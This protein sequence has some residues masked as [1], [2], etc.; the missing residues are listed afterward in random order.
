MSSADYGACLCHD[1]PFGGLG[2]VMEFCHVHSEIPSNPLFLAYASC[3]PWESLT[4]PSVAGTSYLV[5]G[6][7]A[8]VH[9]SVHNE[10]LLSLG[11]TTNVEG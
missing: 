6:R 4:K 1:L 7:Y 9:C 8:G 5:V 10:H 11:R 3:L 2:S